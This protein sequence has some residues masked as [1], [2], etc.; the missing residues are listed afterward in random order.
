MS[1][2]CLFFLVE[3]RGWDLPYDEITKRSIRD[4]CYNTFFTIE[5]PGFIAIQESNYFPATCFAGNL[6]LTFSEKYF[7]IPSECMRSA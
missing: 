2:S 4:T 5:D 1:G 7:P 3:C 6:G